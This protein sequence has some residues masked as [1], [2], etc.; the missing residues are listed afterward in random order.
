M[1]VAGEALMVL[2]MIVPFGLIIVPWWVRKR[3]RRRG[4]WTYT[5]LA[6]LVGGFLMPGVFFAACE[7]ANCGQGVLIIVPLV[8]VWILGAILAL[9]SAAFAVAS[10]PKKVEIR[11]QMAAG[12]NS[13]ARGRVVAALTRSAPHI[14][15]RA[16]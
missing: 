4:V 12:G 3:Q 8:G 14:C 16:Q 6:I 15:C 1:A 9:V 2:L 10:L 5:L 13:K 11:R 7:A